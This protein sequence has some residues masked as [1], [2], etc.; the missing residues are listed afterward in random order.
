[1]LVTLAPVRGPPGEGTDRLE[2]GI[3]GFM[4]CLGAN[5]LDFVVQRQAGVWTVTGTTN[6]M[7]VVYLRGSP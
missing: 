7:W 2:V 4:A 3:T 1:V 6:T 5:G